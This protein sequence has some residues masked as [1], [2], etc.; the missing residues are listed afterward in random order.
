MGDGTNLVV[1]MAGTLLEN[2]ETLL[3]QGLH[4]A[5]I[6]Q[7]YTKASKHSLEYLENLSVHKVE[8][9]RSAE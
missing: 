7:G 5:D 9:V 8:D 4:T 3:R 6:I 1:V 2:A